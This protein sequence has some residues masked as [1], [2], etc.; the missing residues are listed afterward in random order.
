VLTRVERRAD[1]IKLNNRFT[2]EMPDAT[3]DFVG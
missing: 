2:N 3:A 1:G